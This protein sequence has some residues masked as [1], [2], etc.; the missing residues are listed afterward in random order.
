MQTNILFFDI[1]G[2]ILSHR[3]FQISESTRSAIRRA[4][5]NGNLIFVN[6]GR[7]YSEID[8][9][10]IEIG[11]DGFVCGCGTYISY[12]KEV[13]FHQ[14][15]PYETAVSLIKDLRELN[16]E[17]VLEGA[18]AIYFDDNM[19]YYK[20]NDQRDLLEEVFH[21]NVQNWDCPDIT[22]DK[23]CIWSEDA[24]SIRLFYE[25]YKELFHFI[26]REKNQLFE[27]IPKEYS[28]ATGIQYLLKQLDIPHENTYAF[29]DGANDLEMLT[30][31]KHSIGMGNSDGGVP[32]IVSF[33]TKDVDQDGIEYALK[34]FSIIS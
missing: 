5:A 28:K 23:F 25:K 24:D 1:D 7:T 26:D 4:R 18:D 31:V 34:Y 21:F 19:T 11:F 20:L 8:R 3:T 27:V 14:T 16:M 12:Q 29:G 33:L 10:I 6:T 13:L 22:F 15:I 2:T 17:A 9:S 32:E 30:Y